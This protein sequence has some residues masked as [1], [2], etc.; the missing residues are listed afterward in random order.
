MG[1]RFARSSGSGLLPQQI[2]TD[3]AAHDVLF[4]EEGLKGSIN[5]RDYHAPGQHIAP[6]K[7]SVRAALAITADRLVIALSPTYKEL[8]VPRSGPW[9][10]VISANAERA[11]VVCI[12]WQVGAFH[13]DRSGIEEVRLH[14]SHARRIADIL[15]PPAAETADRSPSTG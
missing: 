9:L 7:Q 3:L 13:R 8:D 12:S 1:S 14:T 6:G 11:N 2:R 10:S 4:L 15:A 5:Y